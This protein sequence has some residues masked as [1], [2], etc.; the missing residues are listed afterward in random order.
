[1]AADHSR[2][3]CP[4][5]I[6]SDFGVAFSMGAIGGA[7][8]HGIK[9]WRNSPMGEKR[10]AAMMAIKARAPVSGGNFGAFG[11]L[12][13]IY[14]CMVKGVRRK[15]DPWN[16]IIAGSFTG[17]SLA[18]RG[19]WKSAR[20]SAIGCAVFFALIEGVGLTLSRML[21]SSAKPVAPA[22]PETIN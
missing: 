11:G 2:D 9:G 4:F 5:I 16:A 3:P 10:A 12:F 22:L 19:G 21:A 18:I 13:S 8:W 20:N 15:E 1:M 6:L 17:A 14:D 7:I